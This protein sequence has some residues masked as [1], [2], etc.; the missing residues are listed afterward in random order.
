V[1]DGAARRLPLKNFPPHLSELLPFGVLGGM[2]PAATLR[3]LE[4]VFGAYRDILGAQSNHDFPRVTVQTIPNSD[5]LSRTPDH[6]ICE[7]LE[8]ALSLFDTAG[9]AFAVAPC[10]T[11]H[12]FFPVSSSTVKILHIVRALALETPEF[13][14][15]P[16]LFLSTRQ[17]RAAGVYPL[18][19][20]SLRGRVV[21]PSESDQRLI[22]RIIREVNAGKVTDTLLRLL[23]SVVLRYQVEAV[24]LA[25]TELSLL[26]PLDV[27]YRV[28]DSLEALASATFRVSS[29]DRPLSDYA[30]I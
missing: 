6:S 17:T 15:E 25:C 16:T 2:G 7:A 26:R 8:H 11:L 18:G 19:N 3:F 30:L 23:E 9:V 22:D 5:H 14:S 13:L 27:S 20:E 12:Q 21:F 28:L 24:L 29:G 4:L 1:T 10:N